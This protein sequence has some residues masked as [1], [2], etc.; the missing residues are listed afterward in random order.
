MQARPLFTAHMALVWSM[1]LGRGCTETLVASY[2]DTL[3]GTFTQTCFHMT[4]HVRSPGVEV[5]YR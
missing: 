1:S 3:L 2:P 4:S 5:D